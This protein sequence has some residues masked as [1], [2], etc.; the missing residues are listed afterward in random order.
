M[1][2][3]LAK[4]KTMK[5]LLM[6][7][8]STIRRA[9]DRVAGSDLG[10]N[11]DYRHA[12]KLVSVGPPVA[13]QQSLL[14]WYEVHPIDQ[15]ISYNIKSLARASVDSDLFTVTGLGFVILHRCGSDFY[16]LIV[17]TWQKDNELWQ[18]VW[19]TNGDSMNEFAKVS[20]DTLSLP[21]FCVW[22][23][24]PVWSEQQSWVRLLKSK[25]NKS[26]INRWLGEQYVGCT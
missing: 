17:S 20:G 4:R 23:L 7:S 11:A 8:D 3:G 13:K 24:V 21:T 15:P 26:D 19:Y 6:I 14:K 16:F 9:I 12:D 5:Y 10:V 18:A 25:R 1:R 2:R 22:E